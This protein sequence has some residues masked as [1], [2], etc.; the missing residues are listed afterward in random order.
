MNKLLFLLLVGISF[1]GC[2]KD[3]MQEEP[4]EPHLA[5]RAMTVSSE[6]YYWLGEEK[7]P[8]EKVDGKT[9]VMFD[10]ANEKAFNEELSKVGIKLDNVEI[11]SGYL[12]KKDAGSESVEYKTATI[13]GE[14]E[15]IAPALYHVF[16][17]APY[18]MTSIGG[19]C[20]TNQFSILLKGADDF[21]KLEKLA[22]E[23]TVEILGS[24]HPC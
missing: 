21:G 22:K 9:F 6:L 24:S 12:S 2:E 13:E 23:H 1:Y 14:Y 16:Y 15:K 17:S 18:Y 8:L 20:L 7:I 19:G 5:T 11:V 4:Q 3:F 10:S